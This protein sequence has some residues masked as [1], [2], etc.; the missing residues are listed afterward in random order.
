MS[1]NSEATA[2]K[3][4]L[5]PCSFVTTA[6][7]SQGLA[8]IYPSDTIQTKAAYYCLITGSLQLET[9]YSEVSRGLV[10]IWNVSEAVLGTLV[11]TNTL[12]STLGE[13][14][15]GSRD[16]KLHVWSKGWGRD[17]RS[18]VQSTSY[19]P[20]SAASCCFFGAPNSLT[21]SRPT[22][23]TFPACLCLQ[24]FIPTQNLH[25]LMSWPQ[26][27]SRKE[28]LAPANYCPC[29]WKTRIH[30][31]LCVNCEVRAH[32]RTMLKDNFTYSQSINVYCFQ[33][34]EFWLKRL[35]WENWQ[36]F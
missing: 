21:I 1:T 3:S 34:S 26:L 30:R 33:T 14:Q 20:I 28:T 27:S 16:I 7:W 35:G 6:D 22:P 11:L 10:R 36:M 29:N 31:D 12:Q 19:G 4:H 23:Q 18:L 8:A 2:T 25:S 13:D 24:C 15:H 17:T 32:C 9:K 5:R